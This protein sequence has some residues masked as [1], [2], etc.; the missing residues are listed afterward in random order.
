MADEKES[1][2]RTP[3]GV[4]GDGK[5]AKSGKDMISETAATGAEME[6]PDAE[7]AKEAIAEQVA[8][9]KDEVAQLRATLGLLAESSSQYAVSQV[10]SLREDVRATVVANPFTALIGA[11]LVGYVCGLRGR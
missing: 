3:L 1:S 7:A 11:A 4:V 9:L 2:L 6:A 10:N 5:P 8:A